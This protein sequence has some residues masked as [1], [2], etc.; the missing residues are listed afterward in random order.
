M[1]LSRTCELTPLLIL[2]IFVWGWHDGFTFCVLLKTAYFLSFAE[3]DIWDREPGHLAL[4]ADVGL[5][6][7]FVLLVDRG[8]EGGIAVTPCLSTF[9][10][11]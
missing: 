10:A 4:G 1:G 5:D 8:I 11:E 9:L 2:D 6:S 7:E 3:G